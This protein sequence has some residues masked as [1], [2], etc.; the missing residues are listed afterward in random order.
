M[1]ENRII[2]LEQAPIISYAKMEQVGKE[3]EARIA[4]LNL[5]NLIVTDETVSAVKKTRAELNKDFEVFEKQRKFIKEAVNAPYKEFEEKYKVFVAKHYNEADST[6]K[7]KISHFETKLKK[8]KEV[9]LREY[10]SELSL[11]NDIDF[12]PFERL[13]LDITLI[14]SEKSLKEKI[15]TFISG[16]KKDLDTLNSIPESDDFKQDTL[17]EYKK[18]LDLSKSLREIQDRYKAKAEAQAKAEAE[19]KK[20]AEE[21]PIEPPKP[22]ILQAPKVEEKPK[23]LETRFKV[24]GTLEQLKALKQ[25]IIN[26]NI[27]I[28]E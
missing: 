3:V 26:N 6:L 22:E 21:K 15:N 1:E 12:I 18:N 25:F 20:Q 7:E 27:E 28:V 17:I 2:T 13:Y 19:A 16:I 11:S 8:D 14:A 9:R 5:N 4:E 24:R 23:L 10:F